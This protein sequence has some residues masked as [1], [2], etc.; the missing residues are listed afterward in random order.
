MNKNS[1]IIYRVR[2][3]KQFA[4]SASDSSVPPSPAQKAT[5]KNFGKI[6]SIVNAIMADPIQTAEWQLRMDAF[7]TDPNRDITTPKY[8]TLRKFVFDTVRAQL[9]STQAAKRKRKGIQ[10]AL[11]KGFKLNIKSFAELS[12][13]EL[14]EILKARFSVFYTEQGCR[15]LDMDD[16][17]YIAT[18]LALV[19]KGHVIAYARLFRDTKTNT[20][21]IGRMLTTVRSK[22]YGKSIMTQA[23]E[24]AKRQGAQTLL[25]H[26]QTH[27]VPFYEAFGF[28]AFG[29][30][31][32][33]ADMPHIAMKMELK[34]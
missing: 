7:N 23:I 4:Y 30:I 20:W 3:D 14:Y 2:N 5:R 17:D 16:I 19:Q 31:F 6:N 12:T 11:P 9:E 26:A 28:A 21:Y 13:T 33:E 10:K 15:Y 22:G 24:E 18:H 8:P 1:D 32:S 29:N 27:A 34:D 25:L